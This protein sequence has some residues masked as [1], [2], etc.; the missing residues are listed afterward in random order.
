MKILFQKISRL[1]TLARNDSFKDCH[2]VPC[3]PR[4]DGLKLR[5]FVIT[6]SGEDQYFTIHNRCLVSA[7]CYNVVL[8]QFVA[9]ILCQPGTEC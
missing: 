7:T 6:A 3:P 1:A 2:V 4:N 8:F 9:D 5:S